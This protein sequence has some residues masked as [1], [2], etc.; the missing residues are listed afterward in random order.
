M[1]KKKPI[2]D[3]SISVEKF[4]VPNSAG[5]LEEV[6]TEKEVVLSTRDIID[7]LAGYQIESNSVI[8]TSPENNT[9]N[10]LLCGA[11]TNAPERKI[12]FDCHKKYMK[13]IYNQVS[14]DS[15]LSETINF[16][17]RG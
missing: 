9:G 17:Y 1:A 10:C 14:S 4:E 15:L 8:K 3:K 5:F 13:D 2:Y 11:G 12:C 6:V 16:K 7:M